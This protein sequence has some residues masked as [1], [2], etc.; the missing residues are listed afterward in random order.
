MC[1]CHDNVLDY[2]G[3]LKS[4]LKKPLTGIE[5]IIELVLH[6]GE[7]ISSPGL[8]N[9]YNRARRGNNSRIFPMPGEQ[10]SCEHLSLVSYTPY[11][12]MDEKGIKQIRK[13]FEA[14][15]EEYC[16]AVENNDIGAI[17]ELTGELNK[18]DDYLRKAVQP[19]GVVRNL[20]HQPDKDYRAVCKAVKK[21][22]DCI[23]TDNPEMWEYLNPGLVIGYE[24][25]FLVR[26][27][28][29]IDDASDSETKVLEK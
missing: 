15:Y 2:L 3:R 9:L 1:I 12:A 22:M 29:E 10:P 16:V 24:C 28:D 4:E 18:L 11:Q 8:R 13:S 27:T 25:V 14:T 23:K 21:A 7:Y 20:E 6:R 26:D 17:E 5:Y 19:N